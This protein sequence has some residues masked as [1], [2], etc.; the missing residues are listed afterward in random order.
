ML[1]LCKLLSY[2][3]ESTNNWFQTLGAVHTT[4]VGATNT[5]L[6]LLSSDPELGYYGSLRD[7]AA[8]AFSSEEEW[9]ALGALAKLPLADSAIR[10]R[11]RRNPPVARG[12]MREVVH[13]DGLTLP[14]GNH[15]PRGTWIGVS[16]IGVQ[17]DD[18]FYSKPEEYDP[19]RFARARAE[20]LS[21]GEKQVTRNVA[22]AT[23]SDVF[24][25]FGYGRHSW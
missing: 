5:F 20:P 21:P 4:I 25:A 7:E 19:F 9:G 2:T 16:V 11:L 17:T 10:E 13:K 14:D 24:L 23:S 18:R 6:D 1:G 22:L 8:A 12:T 3:R 15:L